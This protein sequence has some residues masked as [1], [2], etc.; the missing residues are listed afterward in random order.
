[1]IN[2][3]RFKLTKNILLKSVK[4]YTYNFD[5]SGKKHI[6]VSQRTLINDTA[7]KTVTTALTSDNQERNFFIFFDT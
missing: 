2:K 4:R 6:F 1:M 3:N 5:T 7:G